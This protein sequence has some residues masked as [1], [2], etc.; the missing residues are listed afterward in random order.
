M[1]KNAVTVTTDFTTYE[2]ILL[3]V[4]S[5]GDRHRTGEIGERLDP[6]LPPDNDSIRKVVASARKKLEVRNETI[7]CEYR[8]RKFYYRHVKLLSPG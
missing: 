5:D 8:L 7:L 4:L 2:T 6:E 3:D 1:S